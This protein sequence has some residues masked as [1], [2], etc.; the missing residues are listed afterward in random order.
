MSFVETNVR[1]KDINNDK[2]MSVSNASEYFIRAYVKKSFV[3]YKLSMKFR[4]LQFLNKRIIDSLRI[5]PFN[6]C[7][8]N[9][10]VI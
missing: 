3:R 5:L 6:N 10:P 1:N 9:I 4:L 7:F 2:K 8:V